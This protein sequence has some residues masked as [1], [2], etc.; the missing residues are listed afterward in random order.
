MKK[1]ISFILT[2]IVMASVTLVAQN[3]TVEWGWQ[4]GRSAQAYTEPRIVGIETDFNND[5][6]AYY[7]YADS[8]TIGDTSFIH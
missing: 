6:Y 1:S 8:I 4:W 7:W 2:A 3:D 5:F